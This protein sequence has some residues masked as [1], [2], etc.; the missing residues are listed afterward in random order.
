MNLK[1]V[2]IRIIIATICMEVAIN[3]LN[4]NGYLST[5]LGV[6]GVGSGIVLIFLDGY[7]YFDR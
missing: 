7:R 5:A 1:K 4:L 2:G 3:Y 6:F